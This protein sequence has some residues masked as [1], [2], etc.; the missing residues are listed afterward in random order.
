MQLR[1]GI[2]CSNDAWGGLEQNVAKFCNWMQSF[3]HEVIL[4]CDFQT[5]IAQQ[6]Q[7]DNI[8]CL[9]FSHT[10]KHL[11]WQDAKRLAKILKENNIH[12]LIIGHYRHFYLAVWAKIFLKNNIKLVYWQ[13]MQML[14]KRRDVYHTFFYKR[15]DAWVIPLHYL[16]NQLLQNTTLQAQQVHVIP[17]T[18]QTA[19][20]L[21]AYQ[22]KKIARTKFQLPENAFL[23]GTIGRLDR[24]KGQEYLIRAVQQLKE[25]QYPIK[26]LILGDETKNEEGYLAYLQVLV[27]N[28]ELEEDIF[29][30]PFTAETT[31][32][33][34]ALDI[35]AMTSL[36][37]PIGM[38]TI[39]A[40]AAGIP[41]VGTQSGGTPELL[42]WGKAGLLV[43]PQ[44]ETDLANHLKQLWDNEALREDLRQK[45]RQIAIEKYDFSKQCELFEQLLRV[46][47]NI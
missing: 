41:V 12:T 46:N 8:P 18:I 21:D 2:I 15:V 1:F 32:A 45:A 3:R 37:E 22:Q 33:F 43:E 28:L 19:T 25:A 39:E 24:Q 42:E 9:E 34:A 23:V 16:K 47:L 44:N 10:F 11:V 13:Q 36:S 27:Q 4:I 40:M 5:P 7:K 20:F 29:F 14:V 35:F 30:R 31:L 38:V 17:L 26:A 6:A